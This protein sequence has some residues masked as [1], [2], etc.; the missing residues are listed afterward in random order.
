MWQQQNEGAVLAKHQH[1]QMLPLITAP[2]RSPSKPHTSPNKHHN[3]ITNIDPYSPLENK[4]ISY[5][6]SKANASGAPPMCWS[7][8]LCAY[9]LAPMR[10]TDASMPLL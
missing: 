8:R 4:A 1:T 6:A 7:W 2:I 3:P 9:V 10:S 5:L